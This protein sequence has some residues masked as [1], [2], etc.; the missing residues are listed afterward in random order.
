MKMALG[1]PMFKIQIIPRALQSMREDIVSYQVM[2]KICGMKVMTH[3][4]LRPISEHQKLWKGFVQFFLFPFFLLNMNKYSSES[5]GLAVE[6]SAHDRKVV[7][8]I[9]S[10]AGWKWCQSHARIDSCTQSWFIKKLK[11]KKIHAVKW[12][13]PKK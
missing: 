13:T 7:G 5:Y 10:N 9:P 3:F 12:G 2:F 11:R 8:S 4:S 6:N 1:K